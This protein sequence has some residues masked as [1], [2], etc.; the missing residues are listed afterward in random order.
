MDGI[1]Y[2]RFSQFKLTKGLILL[3]VVI[4]VIFLYYA[5]PASY[6]DDLDVQAQ[7]QLQLQ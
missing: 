1:K 5:F 4:A 6:Y 3:F 7:L 2:E